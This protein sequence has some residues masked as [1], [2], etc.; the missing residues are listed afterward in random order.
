MMQGNEADMAWDDNKLQELVACGNFDRLTL[1]L[2]FLLT[3]SPC[4]DKLVMANDFYNAV[5]DGISKLKEPASS[6]VGKVNES[7]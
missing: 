3:A 7:L 5:I 4:F 6:G 2:T 1:H